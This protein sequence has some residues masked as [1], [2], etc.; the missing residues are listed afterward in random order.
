MNVSWS[1]FITIL[2]E[3]L[4]CVG[5]GCAVGVICRTRIVLALLLSIVASA[6]YGVFGAWRAG[7]MSTQI[8]LQDP[9]GTI[10]W[11]GVP[12]VVF[13][14]LP[15]MI[16]AMVVSILWRSQAVHLTNR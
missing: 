3:V 13:Y 6:A 10:F 9:G 1:E 7:T 16:A 8:S 4:I 12:Y 14:L 15:T 5:I 11:L 2:P